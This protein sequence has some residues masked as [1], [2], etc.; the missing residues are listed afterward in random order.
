MSPNPARACALTRVHTSI[1]HAINYNVVSSVVRLS[2]SPVKVLMCLSPGGALL[3]LLLVA[4]I[5]GH[6]VYINLH[7][8][9]YGT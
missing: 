8:A 1:V 7:C 5:L 9:C 6:I 3:W 2:L 4:I